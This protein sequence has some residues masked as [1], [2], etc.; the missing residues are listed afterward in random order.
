M[1]EGI[2]GWLSG[3]RGGRGAEGV[4][5]PYSAIVRMPPRPRLPT[6]PRAG[7]RPSAAGSHPPQRGGEGAE[8][9]GQAAAQAVVAKVPASE[10]GHQRGG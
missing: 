4:C 5:Q 3:A 10:E 2:R 8:L 1:N 7:R 9:R 6:A